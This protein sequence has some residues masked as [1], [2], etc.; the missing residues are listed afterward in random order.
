M[1]TF[2]SGQITQ[3]HEREGWPLHSERKRQNMF[4][5]VPPGKTKSLLLHDSP[6]TALL[7]IGSSLREILFGY[8]G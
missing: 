4:V 8:C 7:S 1:T 5:I 2:R 3:I 6:T